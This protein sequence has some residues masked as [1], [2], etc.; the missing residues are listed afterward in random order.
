MTIKEKFNRID[1]SKLEPNQVNALKVVVEF[2][3]N[4]KT[5]DQSKIDVTNTK[6]DNIIEKL[7]EKNPDA[8][9]PLPSEKKASSTK[10][11]RRNVFSVAK[12]IQKSGESFDEAKKRAS[13]QMKDE[14]ASTNK[15]V[16]T[17]MKS[18]LEYIKK[19]QNLNGIGGTDLKRDSVRYAKPAGRRISKNGNVYY[20]RRENRMDRL[21]PNY[22][23]YA[24]LLANGAY[25]TDPTFGQF[26]S[27]VY[28]KG[29]MLKVEDDEILGYEPYF[30]KNVTVAHI[31][32]DKKEVKP[33]FGYFYPNPM[34]KKVKRWA[35][36]N[37][38]DF[39]QDGKKYELGGIMVTDLAGHTGGGTGGLNDGMPLSGV[40]GTHYSGL[41]GETGAMSAGEMFAEGG[42]IKDQYKGKSPRKIWNMWNKT[43]KIH[44]LK[45]HFLTNTGYKKADINQIEDTSILEYEKLPT[46]VQH[47]LKRHIFMGQYELGGTMPQGTEGAVQSYS[48]AYL[49]QGSDVGMFFE[50]GGKIDGG[51]NKKVYALADKYEITTQFLATSEYNK[52]ITQA[53][54]ESLTDANFHSEAK[55]V[56]YKSEGKNRWSDDLYK[57][58]YFDSSDKVGEFAREV[59][60]LCDYDGLA[61]VNAYYYTTKMQGS[62]V[63]SLIDE[64]FLSGKKS[65]SKKTNAVDFSRFEKMINDS[66]SEEE[67]FD[68]V[69]NA[70]DVSA[71]VSNAFREKYDPNKYLTP[72]QTF[73]KFYK[74]VK[75]SNS[76]ST[77]KKYVPNYDIATVTVK[78]GGKE[79]TYKGSDVLNGANELKKGGDISK[80]GIYIAKRDVVSVTLKN[81]DTIKPANGYWIKKGAKLSTDKFEEGG[82]LEEAVINKDGIKIKSVAMPKNSL[83][84][85]EWMAKHNESNEAR[86]YKAGGS[87]EG[88]SQFIQDEF[89]RAKRE[90]NKFSKKYKEPYIVYVEDKNDDKIG[91][92]LARIFYNYPKSYQDAH[93]VMYLTP[94]SYSYGGKMFVGGLFGKKGEKVEKA[95]LVNYKGQQIYLKNGKIVTVI[96]Q[97]EDDILVKELGNEGKNAYY[98]TVKEVDTE[99]GKFEGGGDVTF[100]EKSHAIAERFEYQKVE[101][102]YQ[103]EYGKVYSEK[104]AEEVGDK[105]AGAMRAK[106]KMSK[107][108]VVKKA[109]NPKMKLATAYANSTR[110]A[111]ESWQSALK[112]GWDSL[113]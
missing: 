4:F 57:S 61:I 27:Q 16:A 112:R 5:K 79:A 14:K 56:V 70:K 86:T 9:K 45:D 59:T 95:K 54:V 69:R 42:V 23:K 99:K 35:D 87:L 40:T 78:K 22:P 43:Q 24:P 73:A 105:I 2:T 47:E 72:R 65:A 7:Q 76:A 53:L 8:V 51:L 66:N 58:E 39:I 12:Q 37:G 36:K 3:E 41:V 34:A 18:L 26:Q 13:Q 93:L 38:Y 6:L 80:L 101:P 82:D 103:K 67:A 109:G 98:T 48:N 33:A 25:L 20:E 97:N 77:S 63:A 29:G 10:A 85:A 15:V 50:G 74:E 100:D 96:N 91:I 88:Y 62:K 106:T 89:P 102:K 81:G 32:K 113:K 1:Q 75:Q 107:G 31:S 92:T 49:N 83:S 110:K 104:E 46:S 55:E 21:S 30:E 90:A 28:A 19:H 84:E 60:A 68:K 111:G 71:E 11:P 108:A 94:V 52:M 17:E 64:M 44:F